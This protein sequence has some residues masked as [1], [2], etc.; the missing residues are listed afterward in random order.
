MSTGG[1]VARKAAS[2]VRRRY[3]GGVS[4]ALATAFCLLVLQQAFASGC[5]AW[6]AAGQ[7]LPARRIGSGTAAARHAA[8]AG[9]AKTVAAP[10]EKEKAAVTGDGEVPEGSAA[11]Y[12][13]MFTS[14]MKEEDTEKDMVTPTLKF[15]G[16]G[17]GVAVGFVLIFMAS[18]GLIKL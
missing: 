2:T 3:A 13:G 12:A 14:P 10:A 5:A 18:N 17:L 9:E 4:A 16:I 6:L 1:V 8:P 7:G 11:Y 15:A